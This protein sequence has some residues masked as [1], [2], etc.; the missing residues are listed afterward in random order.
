MRLRE[1]G[2]GVRRDPWRAAAALRLLSGRLG[3]A[4]GSCCG[5]GT[6]VAVCSPRLADPPLPAVSGCS[7][8]S[9]LRTGGTRC[10]SPFGSDFQSRA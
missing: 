9:F 4:G 6:E 8:V 7:S 10:L 1:A 2:P 3:G 5:F